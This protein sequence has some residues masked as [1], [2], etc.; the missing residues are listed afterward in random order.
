MNR[1]PGP[2]PTPTEPA[3]ES[4][5]F[6]AWYPAVA[7]IFRVSGGSG[8]GGPGPLMTYITGMIESHGIVVYSSEAVPSGTAQDSE[9]VVTASEPHCTP[10]LS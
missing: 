1:S 8:R 5:A 9:S 6:A 3:G 7:A 4:R 2:V 10:L